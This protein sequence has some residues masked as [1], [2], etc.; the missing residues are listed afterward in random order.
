M[1]LHEAFSPEESE[2]IYTNFLAIINDPKRRDKLVWRKN[3][4]RLKSSQLYY[5]GIRDLD[6]AEEQ[7]IK[8]EKIGYSVKPD[9]NLKKFIDN[10][11]YLLISFDV[12]ALD[13]TYMDS[14]GV[15]ADNGLTPD[16]VK[17]IISY[18]NDTQKLVHIDL[19][20][21]NP[22]L[23]DPEKSISSIKTTLSLH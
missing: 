7:L 9:D 11:K 1:K 2:K 12:D 16:E 13:P 5:F 15:M 18:A 6:L 21:F 20:E 4:L 17:N 3:Q 14:T 19:M 8:N 23:G 10:S 22:M